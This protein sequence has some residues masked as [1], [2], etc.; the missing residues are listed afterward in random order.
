[1]TYSGGLARGAFEA[2]VGEIY[3]ITGS[4]AGINPAGRTD[5]DILREILVRWNL[6][7]EPF[8]D[9]FERFAA[10]Y[11]PH[12]YRV[13]FESDRPRLNPGVMEL[14]DLLAATPDVY[15]AIGTGNIERGARIKLKRVGIDHFFPVGGF[16]TDSESR[17][18][19][20]SAA[21][22]NSSVYYDHP[23]APAD[24]W[25][26]GDTPLDIQSGKAIGAN[27][28]GVATGGIPYA[29]LERQRPTALFTDLTDIPR[30]LETIY[31]K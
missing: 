5:R 25:V 12:L 3:G 2:A 6:P 7:Q 4:T 14:L 10:L 31:P 11:V 17:P 30:F 21:F 13:L 28:I 29:E 20:L 22:A 23:F 18:A 15:L 24:T 8:D 27:T 1:L 16:C 19:I 9:L 26:I